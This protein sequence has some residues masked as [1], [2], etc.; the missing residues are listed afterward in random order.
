MR[1]TAL[2]KIVRQSFPTHAI[3]EKGTATDVTSEHLWVVD[4]LDG[5]S[6]RISDSAFCR[7]NWLLSSRH[8]T[9]GSDCKSNYIGLVFHGTRAGGMVSKQERKCPMSQLLRKR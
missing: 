4:P 5:T 6:N 7:I 8:R 3:L 1:N 9:G 2:R